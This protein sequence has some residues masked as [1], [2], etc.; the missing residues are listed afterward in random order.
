MAPSQKQ[1]VNYI[2]QQKLW[3]DRI[4]TELQAA[5]EWEDNWG[6]LKVSNTKA[7]DE[8]NKQVAAEQ[9]LDK[10]VAKDD[11]Q[12]TEA[13]STSIHS[14][15]RSIFHFCFKFF[16]NFDAF[17]SILTK[18]YSLSHHINRS[19]S[20]ASQGSAAEMQIQPTHHGRH[21]VGLERQH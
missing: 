17:E 1:E 15:K 12:T 11:D 16:I 5:S 3:K 21:G 18:I 19:S 20:H 7:E 10:A 4:E 13:K 14:D 6:F 9:A 2:H 8:Y